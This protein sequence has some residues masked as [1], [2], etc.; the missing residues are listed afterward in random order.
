MNAIYSTLYRI[1]VYNRVTADWEPFTYQALTEKQAERIL[2]DLKFTH[3]YNK[4]R[5]DKV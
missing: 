2:E 3:P 4:F 5:I 1:Y